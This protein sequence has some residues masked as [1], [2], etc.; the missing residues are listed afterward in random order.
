MCGHCAGLQRGFRRAAG[1]R[2]TRIMNSRTDRIAALLSDAFAPA[3]VRVADDS[4][5]HAGHAGATAGGQSHFAVLVV[6]DAFDG[7]SRVA[8]AR[9]SGTGRQPQRGLTARAFTVW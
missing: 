1:P 9:A 2:D 4:A 8:R 3:E 5:R 7:L 6:A